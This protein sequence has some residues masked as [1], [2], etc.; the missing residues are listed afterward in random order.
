MSV[1][2]IE[3]FGVL[4]PEGLHVG[5]NPIELVGVLAPEGLHVGRKPIPKITRVP[6][7]GAQLCQRVW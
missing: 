2:T 7:R 4:A 6:G 3:L 5:R 1:E